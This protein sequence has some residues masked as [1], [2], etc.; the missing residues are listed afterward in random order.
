MGRNREHV[1]LDAA[2]SLRNRSVIIRTGL[3]AVITGML[4]AYADWVYAPLWWV[5]Y[6]LIQAVIFR[7]EQTRATGNRF[8]IY[9]MSAASYTVAGYP[10]L[11][12]WTQ[13]GDLGIAAATMFLCGMLLQ[14]VVSSLGARL[15]FWSS[16]GPLIG[17][18]VAVP[19]L[20]FG[21]NRLA[22]GLAVT[23]C[24][25][26]LVGYLTIL[27]LGHQRALDA[28]EKSRLEAEAQ[29]RRAEDASQAKTDFLAAMSHELRTPMNAVLGAG[30]LLRRTQLTEEQ[31]GHLAMLADGGSVL[32]NVLNDILDLSKIEAGKLRI[33]PI[34]ADI[35]D[36]VR[37]C[38]A[39]W[40]GNAQDRGLTIQS[41]ISPGTPRYVVIDP[42][43]VSQIIFNL[44]SNA[45]KFTERGS[46]TLTLSSRPIGPEQFELQF[47]VTDTGIGMDQ[48]TLP[49]IFSAFE[50]ADGS[51]TRRFG[52]T[53]LGLSISQ[54]LAA[55]MDGRIS[56]QSAPGAGSTFSLRL[57]CTL[58]EADVTGPDVQPASGA[59]LSSLRILI[60]ED[61]AT[62]QRVIELF[63]RPL[64][65]DLTLVDD[66]AQALEV[67][68]ISPFDLVLMDLQMPTID[69]LEATR[70]LRSGGGLNANVPVIALTANVLDAHRDA[71]RDAG[72]NG[73]I[74]KPIDSR[75]LL[76]A[77]MTT[78]DGAEAQPSPAPLEAKAG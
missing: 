38:V 4:W 45:V 60:A 43:R 11:H 19:L 61:N 63:L 20:A 26:M 2:V 39:L 15:L 1:D 44:L 59:E 33:D 25:A 17:Y 56:V 22:D 78:L 41:V 29:R 62:N 30:N 76:A 28:L 3:M 27:W 68:A 16:A 69:G 64:G 14:V 50:Q 36:M 71:C 57:P 6:A 35:H 47:S 40:S 5:V 37:R 13:L 31:R 65:A 70:R 42:T 58:G 51:I 32:M 10:S 67:L 8:R 54:K 75:A 66:G 9:V 24:A 18:L 72:M 52:G 53:G 49:R 23:A 34:N 46:I 55:M 48:A 12:L 21:A 77:I 7:I 74:A 73:Y